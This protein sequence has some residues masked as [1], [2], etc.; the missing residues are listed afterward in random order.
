MME[1]KREAAR[2]SNVVVSWNGYKNGQKFPSRGEWGGTREHRR[3]LGKC[4]PRPDIM[5]VRHHQSGSTLAMPPF[6]WLRKWSCEDLG[7][8]MK[9]MSCHPQAG[10]LPN[11][12]RPKKTSKKK[13]YRQCHSPLWTS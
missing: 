5:H 6:L 3:V 1:E 12:L 2:Y 13:R 10:S 4:R 9:G 8:H 7:S 11:S